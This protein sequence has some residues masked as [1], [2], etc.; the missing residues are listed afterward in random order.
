MDGLTLKLALDEN[1]R[2][3]AEDGDGGEEV[4]AD[5]IDHTSQCLQSG[6]ELHLWEHHGE[7]SAQALEEVS[8]ALG[9]L[10]TSEPGLE[11][12]GQSQRLGPSLRINGN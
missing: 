4:A 1:F 11:A 3:V 9:S 7:G 12:V 10:D 6:R 2:E 5:V 8:S